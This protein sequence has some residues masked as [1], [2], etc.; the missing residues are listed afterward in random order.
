MGIGDVGGDG[1]PS[2]SGRW[3][4]FSLVLKPE[5]KGDLIQNLAGEVGYEN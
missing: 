2:I 1:G 3:M 4:P 5:N